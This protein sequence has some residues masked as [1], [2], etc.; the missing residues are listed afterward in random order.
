MGVLFLHQIEFEHERVSEEAD[1]PDFVLRARF[2]EGFMRLLLRELSSVYR[3]ADRLKTSLTD[4]VTGQP[5]LDSLPA[6]V[7]E[8]IICNISEENSGLSSTL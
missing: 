8:F 5:L 3:R 1:N 2:S 6:V 4:H 7:R